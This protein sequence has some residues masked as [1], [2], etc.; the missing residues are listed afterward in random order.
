MSEKTEPINPVANMTGAQILNLAEHEDIKLKERHAA[1]KQS[2]R[3]K[4]VAEKD[5]H[6]TR[7]KYLKAL[8]LV[9]PKE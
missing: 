5:D 6:E 7:Q 2:L 8:A 3:E 1:E 4:Q 9:A